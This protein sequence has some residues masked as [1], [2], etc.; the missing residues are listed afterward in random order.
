ML[1]LYDECR[2]K[3]SQLLCV[4]DQ[5]A[6]FTVLL[7]QLLDLKV[8]LENFGLSCLLLLRKRLL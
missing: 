5:V 4:L 1:V 8:A 7:A 6:H 2:V 3:Y